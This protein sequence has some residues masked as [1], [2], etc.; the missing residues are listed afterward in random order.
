M[1]SSNI[2]AE[3][4]AQTRIYS[5][6]A[7]FNTRELVHNIQ[8]N[9]VLEERYGYK[10]FLPQRDGFEYAQTL[11]LFSL[12]KAALGSFVLP[13]LLFR[14]AH[15]IVIIMI[16]SDADATLAVQRV[17]Y[18]VDMGHF[19]GTFVAVRP[20]RFQLEFTVPF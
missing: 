5:T 15:H 6:A 20:L 14:P 16:G 7:L 12:F 1:L 3:G 9:N 11:E 17:I 19:I 13:I 10:V 8:L 18:L 2:M 4:K